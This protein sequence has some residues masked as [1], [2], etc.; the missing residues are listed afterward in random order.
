MTAT[1]VPI[2]ARRRG[3]ARISRLP[4]YSPAGAV[5][6]AARRAGPTFR[7]DLSAA[8]NLSHATVK[9]QVAA[10]LE[11]GLLRERPDLVPAGAV[12]RPRVPLEVDSHRFGV[13]GVYVGRSRATL[14]VGDP[15]GRVLAALDVPVPDGEPAAVVTRLVD[16]VRRFGARWPERRVLGVGVVVSAELSAGRGRPG[17]DAATLA[18]IPG[19]GADA[20]AVVPQVE[21]MAAAEALVARAPVVG[22]TLYVYAGEVVGA[23]LTSADAFVG[24]TRGPGTISHL[25]V[26]GPARC[27]CGAT[28]CLEPSVGD[29]AVAAAAHRAGVVSEPVIG[30]VIAAARDGHRT[31]HH[32]LVERARLLGR[33]VALV[34][35]VLNPDHVVLLGQAFTGYRPGLAHVAASFAA[36]STLEPLS[37][38]A[39]SLGPRAEAFAACAAALRPVH[40]DPLGAAR[41]IGARAIAARSG[42]KR[43]SG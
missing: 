19:R 40:A 28:G 43:A 10:L 7:D 6:A 24:P 26:G 3:P 4:G 8:T 2:T 35:D 33:G 11:V 31:A 13:L 5:L 34:R 12:G 14:A 41:A 1:V 20:D 29:G 15:R 25:P 18:E 27:H 30:K 38:R 22:A 36:A 9:R 21:A 23:V 17:W 32:L 37:L 16:R 42:S 39:S